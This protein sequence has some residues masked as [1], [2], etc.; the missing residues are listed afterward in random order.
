MIVTR[1]RL[2]G[3][4]GRA[5]LGGRSGGFTLLEVVI[6]MSI[7][8]VGLVS[9]LVSFPHT[10]KS[11]EMAELRT[12]G[13]AYALLKMEEVRRDNDANDKMIDTLRTLRAPTPPVDFPFDPRLAYSFSSTTVLY[14]NRDAAGN[15]VNDPIDPRDDPNV[16]RVIVQISPRFR[17]ANPTILDEY[18]FDK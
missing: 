4:I 14:E 1:Q 18:R 2:G 16:P 9:L 12:L 5:V 3:R 15:V 10:L 8:T 6:G 13:A 7:L 17:P 11:D